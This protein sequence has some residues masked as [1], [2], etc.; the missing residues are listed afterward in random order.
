[1][2]LYDPQIYK[3]RS[4]IPALVC[5]SPRG[6]VAQRCFASGKSLCR[7]RSRRVAGR[8]PGSRSRANGSCSRA[9]QGS[10]FRQLLR[11][12][13]HGKE[14]PTRA[15]PKRTISYMCVK[16]C[17]HAE[18]ETEGEEAVVFVKRRCPRN[19]PGQ[20]QEACLGHMVTVHRPCQLLFGI[21]PDL[22]CGCCLRRAFC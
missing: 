3:S 22:G 13:L 17:G 6:S 9:G 12:M 8:S 16:L 20:R 7:R 15:A 1:M 14:T 21:I 5:S 2:I 11:H 10:P 18:R 19:A 4:R